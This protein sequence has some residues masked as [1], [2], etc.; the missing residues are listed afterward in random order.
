MVYIFTLPV[1]IIKIYTLPRDTFDGVCWH[2][3]LPRNTEITV[4]LS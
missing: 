2:A 1:Y 3:K 4:V